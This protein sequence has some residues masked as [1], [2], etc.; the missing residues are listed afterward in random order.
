MA[1][2][3]VVCCETACR[4]RNV[5]PAINQAQAPARAASIGSREQLML[6]A[7]H[8]NERVDGLE[9]GEFHPAPPHAAGE[10]AATNRLA[11][12]TRQAVGRGELALFGFGENERSG[13]RGL[14]GVAIGSVFF[15][16]KM[17]RPKSTCSCWKHILTI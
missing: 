10:A 2:V 6:Q 13:E 16:N 9:V 15:S 12:R 8:C 14:H 17:G 11:R 1:N 4:R 5:A 7:N 3:S